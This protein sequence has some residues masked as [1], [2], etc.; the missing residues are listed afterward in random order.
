MHELGHN[1]GS[2]HTHDGYNP[3]VDTC[4][5]S[6]AIDQCGVSCPAQLPLA[7]SA[8]IMSYCDMCNGRD[9]NMDYTF[10]GKYVSGPRNIMASYK[11][12]PLAGLGVVSNEPRRVNAKMWS[13]VSTR[14]RSCTQ[15]PPPSSSK[16]EAYV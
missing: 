2:G 14:T 3:V 7:K 15:P 5:T 13:H 1:F 4:G 11:N 8:T 10:G 12:S 6:C 16:S 9:S